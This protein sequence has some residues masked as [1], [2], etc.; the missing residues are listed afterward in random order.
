MQAQGLEAD[1]ADALVSGS[2]EEPYFRLAE[3]IDG[4]H[5]IAHHEQRA[6]VALVPTRG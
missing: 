2:K 1:G 4:L 6:S 5:R 3:L